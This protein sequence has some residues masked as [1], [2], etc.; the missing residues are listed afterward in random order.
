M[1]I[2]RLSF[3]SPSPL[4]LVFG[5]SHLCPKPP[6]NTISHI[7]YAY[8]NSIYHTQSHPITSSSVFFFLFFLQRSFSLI[9]V[10]FNRSYSFRIFSTLY[11]LLFF[12]ISSIDAIP[13]LPLTYSFLTLSSLVTPL[14]AFSSL[15]YLSSDLFSCQPYTTLNHTT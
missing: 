6:I 10:S 11:C 9:H 4:S 2:F 5:V 7:I 1:F 8:I 3:S 15:L 13:M 12:V 14:N